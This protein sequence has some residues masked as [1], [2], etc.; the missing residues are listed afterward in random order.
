RRERDVAKH[1]G[2]PATSR[3]GDGKIRQRAEARSNG[4]SVFHAQSVAATR[5]FCTQRRRRVCRQNERRRRAQPARQPGPPDDSSCN[6]PRKDDFANECARRRVQQV[7]LGNSQEQR[8]KSAYRSCR[9]R[10][11]ADKRTSRSRIR[12][13]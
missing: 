7:V 13:L 5:V 11:S 6:V 2:S 12:C 8:Q 3:R 10:S 9:E 1:G 4:A